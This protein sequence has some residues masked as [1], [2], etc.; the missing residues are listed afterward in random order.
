MTFPTKGE[1]LYSLKCFIAAVLALYIASR[2]ALPRPF[3]AMM[4]A[5]IVA[6][7]MAGAVRSKAVYRVGGTF[8]GCAMTLF[9]VPHLIN[10]PELLS[11]ALAC[12]VGL[13]LYI[14]LLDRTPR[15][16][17]FMLAGYTA[18]L[19][20]FPS[21]TDPL[22][23]FDTA[24]ARVEEICIGILCA[25]LVHTVILPQSMGKIL[26]ARID[27][28]RTDVQHWINDLIV[29]P[30]SQQT[31]SDRRTLA[32]DITELRVM[33]T[34]LPFDTSN[35]RWVSNSMSALEDKLT[36]IIPVL[37]SIENRLQTLR[38]IG[39]AELAA[40]YGAVLQEI[41]DWIDD[42]HPLD[43]TTVAA[44]RNKIDAITPAVKAG[45]SWPD[46]LALNLATQLQV[47]IDN[48]EV[49]RQLRDNIG[50]VSRGEKPSLVI[51]QNPLPSS[52]LH[53][54]HGIAFRSGFAA[55]I[56]ILV[57]CAAWIFTGWSSGAAAPMMAAVF[58]CLFATQDNPVAGIRTYVKFMYI[59]IPISAFYLLVA[60]PAV[61][62]FTMMVVVIA[63]VF[64]IIGCY[65]G[66]PATA[67][68]VL[69]M[70]LGVLGTLSLQD[71]NTFNFISF[72]DS[73]LAQISG[74][75]AAAFFTRL[76]RTFSAR[77]TA[78]RLL[79]AGWRELAA[80]ATARN[81]P[82]ITEM[83]ARMLDRIALLTPRLAMSGLPHDNSAR[84]ALRDLRIG[85]RIVQLRH[86]A[87]TWNASN[88][89]LPV[90][91]TQLAAHFNRQE[92][93]HAYSVAADQQI[94]TEAIDQALAAACVAKHPAAVSTLVS[95]RQD[96][97]PDAPAYM[98]PS[99]KEEVTA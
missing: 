15:S 97:L 24:L 93:S 90:L 59:S 66:R 32:A 11:L 58:C 46:V 3:W 21:V 23:L 79:H 83:T 96:L 94:L 67:L 69:A 50:R 48:I 73:N 4:T 43:S 14:S 35:L 57:C 63:P 81:I 68:P 10:S 76:L 78:S 26:L 8:L 75:T 62:S 20:A 37:S 64:L 53:R 92:A 31:S 33:S 38:S 18:A 89:G 27:K 19:I 1:M 7:P 29:S 95:L 36:M 84:D 16:Y 2:L 88:I 41:A 70:Y 49:A 13:C 47:L 98:P 45:S 25:S 51:K 82:P 80:L 55:A 34:H 99:A 6:S 39:Q 30:E 54:D 71:T 40:R 44:V 52:A 22:R 9:M 72:V 12:W 5:Y 42:A 91:M 65:A 87:A 17:V 61:D 28:M 77:W 74:I 56:A 86:I 85:L 60:L